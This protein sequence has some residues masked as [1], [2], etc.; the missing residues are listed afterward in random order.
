MP[1]TCKKRAKNKRYYIADSDKKKAASRASYKASPEKKRAASRASY[2][3]YP[4]KR[5]AASRA[6]YKASPEKKRAASRSSYKA[7]TVK[8]VTLSLSPPPLQGN[9]TLHRP[10]EHSLHALQG[11]PLPF[12]NTA[13]RQH[14]LL[15]SCCVASLSPSRLPIQ[16]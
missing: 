13:P 14:S 1:N 3:A 5:K 15:P 4:D 12:R 2:K 10:L 8:T 7:D 9:S 11:V 6:S 16:R